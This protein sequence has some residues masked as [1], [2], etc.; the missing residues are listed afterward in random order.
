MDTQ[1]LNLRTQCQS[2]QA[3]PFFLEKQFKRMLI[4][5]STKELIKARSFSTCW[6]S[7]SLT[8]TPQQA[9]LVKK[10]LIKMRILKELR[11]ILWINIQEEQII[12]V[13]EWLDSQ[14]WNAALTPLGLTMNFTTYFRLSKSITLLTLHWMFDLCQD[15]QKLSSTPATILTI[16]EVWIGHLMSC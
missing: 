5:I 6:C 14:V 3:W 4:T 1:A 12:S 2:P 10:S 8:S 7:W 13:L 9:S 11:D 15:I 16:K